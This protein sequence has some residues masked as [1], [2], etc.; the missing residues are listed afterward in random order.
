MNLAKQVI[1]GSSSFD[2]R[3]PYHS[4][5]RVENDSVE[6]VRSHT[7]WEGVVGAKAVND[8]RNNSLADLFPRPRAVLARVMGSLG[9]TG[10]DPAPKKVNG[11]G[12]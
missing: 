4:L 8:M 7:D 2:W 3:G 12:L 5:T 6:V 10:D 1:E 9:D 11:P